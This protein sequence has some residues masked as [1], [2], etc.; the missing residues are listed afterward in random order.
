[1]AASVDAGRTWRP[2][3]VYR[4]GRSWLALLTIPAGNGCVSLR[5]SATDTAGDPAVVTTI[6][7]FAAG[8]SARD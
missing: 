2:V 1:M 3:H 8:Q 6:R 5:T 4:A 7:A